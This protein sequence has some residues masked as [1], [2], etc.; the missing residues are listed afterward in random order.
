MSS[1]RGFAKSRQH[2]V[3]YD[4]QERFP[5]PKC[6]PGTREPILKEVDEWTIAGSETGAGSVMWLH[7][8]AGAGKSAIAQTVAEICTDRGQLAASFFFFRGSHHRNT[9][10]F[11]FTTIAYQLAISRRELKDYIQRAVDHDRSII[12]KSTA[13]QVRALIIDPFYFAAS[14]SGTTNSQAPSVII[15]DGLDECQGNDNQ[16]LVL[17]H[18]ADLVGTH[19]L[20]FCFL[21]VSRVIRR[22]LFLTGVEIRVENFS[23]WGAGLGWDGSWG[24]SWGG[25]IGCVRGVGLGVGGWD[26]YIESDSGWRLGIAY[27]GRDLGW[28]D[29]MAYVG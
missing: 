27:V 15:I 18:I 11:L 16:R 5:P 29:G 14:L 6:H 28:M 1:D 7:G 2:Q 3:A 12:H 20:P 19:R 17:S 24:R 23:D 8:P 4:S 25:G 21:V 9:I 13:A 26:A 22:D 10:T